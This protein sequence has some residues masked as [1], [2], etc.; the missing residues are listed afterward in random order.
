MSNC[1]NNITFL[2]KETTGSTSIHFQYWK[3]ILSFES[4]W[5]ITSLHFWMVSS[6]SM[7]VQRWTFI[8]SFLN[9][10]INHIITFP[11][12][13]V[14]T[15]MPVQCF[16][17]FESWPHLSHPYISHSQRSRHQFLSSSFSTSILNLIY[18]ILTFLNRTTLLL[19]EAL[20]I[21]IYY[22]LV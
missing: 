13:L 4:Q 12:V 7:P 6:T 9:P 21:F 3:F 8:H 1:I 18:H 22:L 19:Q 5:T 16:L 20:A 14:S 10:V 17:D 15:S 2:F 11:T